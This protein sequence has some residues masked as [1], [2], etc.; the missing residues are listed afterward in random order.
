MAGRHLPALLRHTVQGLRRGK[1]KSWSPRIMIIHQAVSV[2]VL[3]LYIMYV[4]FILPHTAQPL[5]TDRSLLPAPMNTY[6]AP[7]LFMARM[8]STC[9][10]RSLLCVSSLIVPSSQL[11]NFVCWL[12]PP[13]KWRGRWASF[14]MEI[15]FLLCCAEKCP[16]CQSMCNY[17][18][19][20]R[21]FS[22]Q[23]RGQIFL[24]E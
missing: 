14:N 20:Q 18:R 3:L 12:G 15:L 19:F 17:C 11:L 8:K 7:L 1:K 24:S 23:S 2:L 22:G 13:S 16:C 21:D 10:S 9:Q 5:L 6:Q 4:P